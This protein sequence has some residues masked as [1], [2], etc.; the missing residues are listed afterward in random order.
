MLLLFVVSSSSAGDSADQSK[1]EDSLGIIRLEEV[2]KHVLRHL[3]CNSVLRM[4]SCVLVHNAYHKTKLV[5]VTNNKTLNILSPLKQLFMTETAL[6]GLV[7]RANMSHHFPLP[8]PIRL[9]FG[10]PFEGV[11]SLSGS[12]SMPGCGEI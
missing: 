1:S 7:C 2:D 10:G 4:G 11:M 9:K 5:T 12:L 3:F 6:T 8:A